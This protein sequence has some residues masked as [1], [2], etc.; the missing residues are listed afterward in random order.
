MRA[1]SG[2]EVSSSFS[3]QSQIED[4]SNTF[5]NLQALP[6]PEPKQIPKKEEA[7]IVSQSDPEQPKQ[8]PRTPDS[9]SMA[10]AEQTPPAAENDVQEDDDKPFV[11]SLPA[12]RSYKYDDP[13]IIFR[14]VDVSL[15]VGSS[16][17]SQLIYF[18]LSR[19]RPLCR[20]SKRW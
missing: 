8:R 4:F 12:R 11:S 10:D 9:A 18:G 7:N 17:F 13:P 1:Q 6:E 19:E 15:E 3:N 16:I 14:D 20:R 2:T 5:G